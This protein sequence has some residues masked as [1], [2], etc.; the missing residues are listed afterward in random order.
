MAC[1]GNSAAIPILAM[2]PQERKSDR[3]GDAQ[4]PRGALCYAD[5]PELQ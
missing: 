3:N 5:W 1:I 2:Q 4:I